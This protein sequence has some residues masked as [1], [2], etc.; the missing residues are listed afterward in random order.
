MDHFYGFI[1][2]LIKR[3]MEDACVRRLLQPSHNGALEK[4]QAGCLLLEHVVLLFQDVFCDMAAWMPE[5]SEKE[6]W[7]APSLSASTVTLV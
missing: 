2:S 1:T 5:G 4:S 7:T 6:A 3:L